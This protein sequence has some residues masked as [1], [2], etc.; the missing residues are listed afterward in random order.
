MGSEDKSL[1]HPREVARIVL[2]VLAVVGALYVL[3]L[4]RRP[5]GYVV[6]ASFVAITLSG[7]VNWLSRHMKR[8][9]AIALTYFGVLMIPVLLALIVIPPMVREGTHLADKAPTYAQDL[10]DYVEKNK[11]LRELDDKYD[12]TGKLGE[13]AGKLP[14]KVGDAA[15]TLGDIGVGLVN[16]LFALVQI[17]ILSVFLVA[18]G[19]SWLDRAVEW[20]RPREAQRIGAVFDR[21]GRTFANYIGGALLQA[22]IAALISYAVMRILSV[23]FAAPLAVATFFFDLLPLVG[24]TIGAIL[25]AVVTVFND[26]PTATIIWV[27]FAIVYQ[28]VENS[29]IQPQIQRRAVAVHPFAVLVGVLFGATLFGI[30]GALLA[31]P[32]IASGEITLREWVAYRAELSRIDDDPPPAAAVATAPPPPPAPA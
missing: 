22:T 19:R 13:E 32:V 16:R 11:R 7:P 20:R 10:K 6:I 21:I 26:F 8:G 9:I 17:L 31:I 27:I 18:N 14:S 3:Y 29:L 4:L 2:T 24:A 12:I 25:V 1:I 28:Q 30:L 15:T 5:I 23:P